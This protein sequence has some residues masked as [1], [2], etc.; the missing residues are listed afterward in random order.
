MDSAAFG[1]LAAQSPVGGWLLFLLCLLGVGFVGAP[2][3]VWTIVV[4]AFGYLL[5]VNM[6]LL[7]VVVAAMIFMSPN[8]HVS[9]A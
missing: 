5:G 4:A 7:G 8:R 9:P 3:V 1:W 6:V 2:L